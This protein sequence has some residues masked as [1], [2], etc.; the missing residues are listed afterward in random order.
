VDSFEL[1]NAVSAQKLKKVKKEKEV[2]A[3]WKCERTR[4][5]KREI[6]FV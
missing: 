4:M 6:D 2:G 3:F 1:L 5:I